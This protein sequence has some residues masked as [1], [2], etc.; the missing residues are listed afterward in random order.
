MLRHLT[1]LNHWPNLVT[2]VIFSSITIVSGGQTG[3][4]RA[5]LDWAIANGILCSGWCP[6][7]RLA[8]DGV[9]DSRYPLKETPSPGYSQRTEWNVRDSDGT[10]IFSLCPELS[11][12]SALTKTFSK[13]WN[14]PCLHLFPEANEPAKQL[15]AFVDEFFINTLNIAGPRAASENRIERFVTETLN[16]AFHSPD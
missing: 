11:G 16:Q 3:A 14:R 1:L 2:P 15:V 6:S 12:G 7:G 4:D 10:V 5:G 13:K 8:E 9:I